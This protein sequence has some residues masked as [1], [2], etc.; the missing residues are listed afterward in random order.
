MFHYNI[1]QQL[2]ISYIKQ[3]IHTIKFFERYTTLK[4]LKK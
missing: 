1:S 4:N 3:S 2:K